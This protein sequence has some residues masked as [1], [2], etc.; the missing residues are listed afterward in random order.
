VEIIGDYFE[1]LRRDL[2]EPGVE[3]LGIKGCVLCDALDFDVVMS[4]STETVKGACSCPMLGESAMPRSSLG[5]EAMEFPL[6]GNGA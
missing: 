2:E 6:Q 4:N 3:I 1:E 5:R